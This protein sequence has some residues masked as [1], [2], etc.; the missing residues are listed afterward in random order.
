M[1][2]ALTKTD[3]GSASIRGMLSLFCSS[4]PYLSWLQ[5]HRR[6]HILNQHIHYRNW[7]NFLNLGTWLRHKLD[8][9]FVKRSAANTRI[10]ASGF[11]E[12]ALSLEWAALKGDAIQCAPSKQG[13]LSHRVNRISD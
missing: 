11:S 3:R 2:G 7:N 1:L 9:L 6:I 4:T 10:E 13:Y 12:V 8:A 5:F